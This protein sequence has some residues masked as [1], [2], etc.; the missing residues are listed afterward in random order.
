[1]RI[2]RERIDRAEAANHQAWEDYLDRTYRQ[3]FQPPRERSRPWGWVSL[4]AAL[5][6]VGLFAAAA[7]GL[8]G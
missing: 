2:I 6:L 8:V 1:M 3:G 7:L 4:A 5:M